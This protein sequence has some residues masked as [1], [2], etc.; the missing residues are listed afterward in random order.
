[1]NAETSRKQ[2]PSENLSIV[3]MSKDQP[4]KASD[5]NR[6]QLQAV[7][8]ALRSR[9]TLI[10]GPPGKYAPWYL[11]NVWQKPSYSLLTVLITAGEPSNVQKKK[12][13]ET[14]TW[15]K[16]YIVKDSKS[17]SMS[18]NDNTAYAFY[19]VSCPK[20]FLFSYFPFLLHCCGV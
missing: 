12:N 10:Q 13:S 3:G 11:F 18:R 7:K 9:F 6:D 2:L 8:R 1:M 17:R 19:V 4:E 5:L 16:I 20:A 15:D 14:K